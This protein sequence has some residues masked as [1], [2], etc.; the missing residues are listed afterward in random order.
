MSPVSTAKISLRGSRPGVTKQ[1]THTS[2]MSKRQIV[3]DFRRNPPTAVLL[4]HDG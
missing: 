3:P 2:E 1:A 4:F